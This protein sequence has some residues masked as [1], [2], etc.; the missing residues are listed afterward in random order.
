MPATLFNTETIQNV[1][2]AKLATQY[3]PVFIIDHGQPAHVLM[4]IDDYHRITTKHNKIADLLAMPE[5][6]NMELEIP[7]LNDLARSVDL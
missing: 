4:T 1:N 3:G 6:A 2:Q 5:I 7:T